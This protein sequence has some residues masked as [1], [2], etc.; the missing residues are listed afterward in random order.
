MSRREAWSR[1]RVLASGTALAL[2]ACAPADERRR[3]IRY[4]DGLLSYLPDD[5]DSLSK[6]R[7]NAFIC[8]VADTVNVVD[9]NGHPV[10]LR[11]FERC[12]ESIEEAKA[13]IRDKLPNAY[14]ALRGSDILEREGAGVFL[15][16]QSCEPIGDDLS[17]I[18]YFHGKELRL[19]QITHHNNN[20]FGGGSLEREPIGLTPLGIEGVAEMNRVGIVP[21]VAHASEKTALD[22]ARHTKTPFVLSHG[23]CYSIVPNVRCATDAM[24]RAIADRGGVMGIFMMSFWLTTDDV[25]KPEHFLAHIRHVVKIGGIDAVGVANDLPV[26]G[27][28]ELLALGNNN[29]EGVKNYLPWWN[30]QKERG[31]RGFENP[32]KHVVIPEFNNIQRME[33]IQ[34]L[35]EG[36]GFKPSEVEKIMGGNWIRVLTDVLG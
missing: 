7:I 2:S 19:L 26:G 28:P 25:P 33:R 21:D 22:V 32:P 20:L 18:S 4:V 10:Y 35:L 8:D 3:P 23:G 24:I 36:G 6:S 17:R 27:E 9:A 30:A 14:V 16:F 15:Q 11:T 31:I 12:N 13:H 1:R 5:A 34:S 29:A